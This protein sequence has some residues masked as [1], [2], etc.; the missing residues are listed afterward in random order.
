MITQN[1]NTYSITINHNTQ[2]SS[3]PYKELGFQ[4]IVLNNYYELPQNVKWTMPRMSQNKQY[5]GAKA[6]HENGNESV[7]IWSALKN[8]FGKKYLCRTGC[9]TG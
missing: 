4:D 1:L 3:F 8:N 6:I 5:I 2:S 7:Y 9:C